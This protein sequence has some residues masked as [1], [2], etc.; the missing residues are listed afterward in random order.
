MPPACQ[1]RFSNRTASLG[2]RSGVIAPW[3]GLFLMG[4]ELNAAFDAVERFNT[5]AYCILMGMHLGFSDANWQAL[6][7]EIA[8]WENR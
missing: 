1:V 5:N 6:Q 2:P 7:G 3:H 4:K 8:G